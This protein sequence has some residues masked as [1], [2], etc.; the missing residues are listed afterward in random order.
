MA[1]PAELRVC[2]AGVRRAPSVED[3]GR[4]VEPEGLPAPRQDAVGRVRRAM[5][6]EQETVQVSL[7]MEAKAPTP[8]LPNNSF[9]VGRQV[10]PDATS[11]VIT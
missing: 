11:D 9:K 3:S 7:T 10:S 2:T 6:R 5:R 8:G 4:M 1:A